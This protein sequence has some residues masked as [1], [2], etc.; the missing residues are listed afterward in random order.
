MPVEPGQEYRHGPGGRA[1]KR[2][3]IP[4]DGLQS[5]RADGDLALFPALAAHA[6]PLEPYAERIR[7]V[8]FGIEPATWNEPPAAA[9][10]FAPGSLRPYVLF[11]GRHV[12]YK[13]VD[14]LLRAIAAVPSFRAVIVGDGPRRSAWETLARELNLGD[15]AC[16]TGE[17]SDAD[18]KALMHGCAALVLPSVTR[19]EAFGY[20]QLEAMAAGVPVISTD[21]PSGVSW[22]N[23]HERTGIIVPAGNAEA[24]RD[25]IARFM[26]DPVLRS[27]LGAAGRDRVRTEFT[28]TRLRDRL[29]DVYE[30]LGLLRPLPAAC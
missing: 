6:K 1:R 11:A 9:S 21:V 18:L 15:R 26:A 12:P 17:V 7:V 27:R 30:E 16:F 20:V 4:V 10:R 29:R 25:A 13:G 5:R 23:Q 14:V 19:A 28:M 2:S 3:P 22:V 8:P 24:L